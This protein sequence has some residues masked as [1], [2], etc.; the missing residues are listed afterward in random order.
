MASITTRE[1]TGTGATVAGVP[2]TN[3][4]L[5]NNFINLNSELITKLPLTGGTLTGPVDGPEYKI[6]GVSINRSIW[7]RT[8]AFM[9]V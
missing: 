3:Q 8:F 2:L 9:G 5:D 6:N 1:T 4:Q 7:T